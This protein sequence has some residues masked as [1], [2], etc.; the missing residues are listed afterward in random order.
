MDQVEL[1]TDCNS[2]TGPSGVGV[3]AERQELEVQSRAGVEVSTVVCSSDGLG[4][5]RVVRPSTGT[6]SVLPAL[7][8]YFATQ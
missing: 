6:K 5:H 1:H 3:A 4:I 8:H 2:K 7:I